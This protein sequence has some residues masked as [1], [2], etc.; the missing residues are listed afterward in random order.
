MVVVKFSESCEVNIHGGIG[1]QITLIF[2]GAKLSFPSNKF[3][4]NLKGNL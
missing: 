1:G 4:S 3:N 2:G